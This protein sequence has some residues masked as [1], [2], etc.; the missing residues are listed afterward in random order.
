MLALDIQQRGDDGADYSV[1]GCLDG[2]HGTV[3]PSS[4]ADLLSLHRDACSQ[5]LV[6]QEYRIHVPSNMR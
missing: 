6:Q 4:S 1:S 2:T 5:L 3:Q